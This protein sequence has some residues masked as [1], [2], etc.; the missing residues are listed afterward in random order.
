MRRALRRA[1]DAA[2]LNLDEISVLLSARDEALTQLCEAAARVR[3]AG[4]L[5]IGR[6]GV[7]TYSPKVFIPLTRLCRDR[8]HYCTFA[9][10]PNHVPAAY[11]EISQVC[12]LI[13]PLIWMRI[14]ESCTTN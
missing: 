12:N 14:I 4:L 11:L 13:F 8:C 2:T 9:T 6:P 5:E 1:S 7:I 3:D 10:T